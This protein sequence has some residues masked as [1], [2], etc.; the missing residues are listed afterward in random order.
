M[1]FSL[2]I[3]ILISLIAYKYWPHKIT[4]GELLLPIGVSLIC[5]VASYYFMKE[6]TIHDVEFNGE[7]VVEARYYE[8]WETYVDQTC[9]R[10]YDCGTKDNP[11][12]CTETYDC[13]YCDKNKER[14]EVLLRDGVVISVGKAKY[15]ELVNKWNQEPEFVELNRKINNYSRCGQD[16][17]MYRVKWDGKIKT[18]QSYVKE[19]SFRN[20]VKISHSAFKFPEMSDIEADSIGLYH[21][22]LIYSEYRQTALLTHFNYDDSVHVKFE[23]L[24]GLL[25]STNK[26]KVFTLLFV[27]KPFDIALKQE[28]Y[29]EGGNQNELIVC[30]GVDS[31]LN[32][33]WVKPFSWCDN[34]RICIDTRE[35]ISELKVFYP[36]KVIGIYYKN[37]PKYFH[38]KS[39]ADFN[40]L[41]F[42]PTNGQLIFVYVMTLLVS[43]GCCIFIVKNEIEP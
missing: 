11:Q 7:L 41:K 6:T 16:G 8:Y 42:S 23:Y 12:T 25:G 3:P 21:Y 20:P 36:D 26:V 38:Y 29:F 14:Y 24:N 27:N 2:L 32:I 22:P 4:V 18:S 30:I 10:T 1:W 37:I 35:D 9:T 31:S 5:V 40:Y 28:Q 43:I 34:K 39:F 17:D 19:V 33:Q 15:L 13:S